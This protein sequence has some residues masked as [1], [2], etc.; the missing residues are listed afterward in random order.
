MEDIR[1]EPLRPILIDNISDTWRWWSSE[2]PDRGA[3]H[4][5]L[6]VGVNA[7]PSLHTRM[8]LSPLEVVKTLQTKRDGFVVGFRSRVIVVCFLSCWPIMGDAE[9]F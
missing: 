7:V 4:G 8:F 9:A 2:V 3:H 1:M 5:D 6:P